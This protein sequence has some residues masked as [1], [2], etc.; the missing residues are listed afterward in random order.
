MTGGQ[1]ESFLILQSG[2]SAT[3]IGGNVSGDIFVFDQSSLT[4][5][6]TSFVRDGI[7]VTSTLSLNRP[8]P[9]TARNEIWDITLPDGALLN[10]DTNSTV[11]VEFPGVETGATLTFFRLAAPGMPNAD[12]T[13]TGA[14]L[15]N[16][17]GFGI[18]DGVVDL[19]DLGFFLNLWLLG[20]P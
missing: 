2:A 8:T 14:T 10:L 12:V 15:P 4:V 9:I 19:D 1:L 16:Q 3:I 5:F 6:G 13:T 7:D 17:D 20:A 18:P 11:G